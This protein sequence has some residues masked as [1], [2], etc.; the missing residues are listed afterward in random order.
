MPVNASACNVANAW[1]DWYSLT[2]DLLSLAKAKA[3]IDQTTRMQNPESGRIATC[4]EWRDA[5]A[6]RRRSFWANCSLRSVM[7]LLR[8]DAMKDDLKKLERSSN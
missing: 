1:L 8:A 7:L 4:W 5:A 2:G 3:L 6:D